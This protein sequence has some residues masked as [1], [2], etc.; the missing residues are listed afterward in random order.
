M[1]GKKILILTILFSCISMQ[2]SVVAQRLTAKASIQPYEIA[3]GQQ[4][5]ISLEVIAPKGRQLVMPAFA[6]TLVSGLEVLAKL[7]ADTVYAHEVMTIT[8]KYIVT[9]FDSALYHI[10]YMPVIDGIDTIKS[11]GFGLKVV[12]PNLSEATLSYLEQLKTQQTDSLEFDKLGVFDIKAI[13]K[14]PFVWQD[15]II[16]ILIVLLILLVLVAVGISIYMYMQKKK[17]G[18]YFKPIVI[19]PPHIVALH[20]LNHVKEEKLWQRGKEKEYFTEITDILR[21]YIEDRFGVNAFEMTSDEIINIINNFMVAESSEDGLK[22]V[23]KLAD[24]V[25]FAKYKPLLD[26]SNLSLVNAYL[27]V[28]QTKKEEV[29]VPTD[30]TDTTHDN[31]AVPYEEEPINWQITEDKDGN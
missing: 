2:F 12:S 27:F 30:S 16:Y 24:L 18:Y 25:K 29:V 31:T 22:Q 26:E 13:Q 20:A 8:Q 21:K 4:A 17:K 1:L 28:N 19:D 11:N 5:T 15:Y 23:L 6:D 3:I 9:S 10:P 7:K 14:P